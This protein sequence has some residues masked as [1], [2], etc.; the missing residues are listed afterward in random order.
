MC[1]NC[2]K[3]ESKVLETRYLAK[4]SM[5][6]RSRE[7]AECGTRYTTY[8]T[9]VP[10]ALQI[11]KSNGRAQPFRL[12]KLKESIRKAYG[13]AEVDEQVNEVAGLVL[14][15]II[16]LEQDEVSS[17][18]VGKTVERHLRDSTMAFVRYAALYRR[19]E[20]VEGIEKILDEARRH[21]KRLDPSKRRA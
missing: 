8:E 2:D 13:K 19:S 20:S 15:E 21:A 16:K 11:I 18:D 5:I 6:R 14:R 7:C 3:S 12:D 1:P 10:R 17:L 4:G 9:A